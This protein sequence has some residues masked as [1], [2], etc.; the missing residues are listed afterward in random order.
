[1]TI[2][3]SAMKAAAALGSMDDPYWE[4]VVSL[5]NFNNDWSDAKGNIITPYGNSSIDYSNSLYGGGCGRFDNAAGTY[6]VNYLNVGN[7]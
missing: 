5:I 4:N 3:R 6:G 2:S 7:K 1:M